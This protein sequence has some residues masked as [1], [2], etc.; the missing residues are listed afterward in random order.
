MIYIKSFEAVTTKLVPGMMYKTDMDRYQVE[1]ILGFIGTNRNKKFS[2][3][4]LEFTKNKPVIIEIQNID[5]IPLNISIADYII[6]MDKINN[7]DIVNKTLNI[8]K[9]PDYGKKTSTK[10]AKELYNE[11]LENENIQIYLASKK[12]NL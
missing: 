7:N 1:Y 5:M 8:L 11:L 10:I 12:Y 2:L 4:A 6:K 3:T 9:E